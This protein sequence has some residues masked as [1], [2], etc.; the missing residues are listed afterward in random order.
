MWSMAT[1]ASVEYRY[2]PVKSVYYG[3]SANGM[4]MDNLSNSNTTTSMEKG[5][6]T[7]ITPIYSN[8][9]NTRETFEPAFEEDIYIGAG[10]NFSV[11]LTVAAYSDDDQ[12]PTG[13]QTY[14]TAE[15][16][17]ITTTTQEYNPTVVNATIDVGGLIKNAVV[18]A[19]QYVSGPNQYIRRYIWMFLGTMVELARVPKVSFVILCNQTKLPIS[20]TDGLIVGASVHCTSYLTLVRN[21]ISTVRFIPKTMRRKRGIL[22]KI[23]SSIFGIGLSKKV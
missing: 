5:S 12:W 1:S 15:A 11:P 9:T 8:N 17:V 22:N 14:V 21:P 18:V 7:D 23:K 4:H 10:T 13:N 2:D 19:S 3:I 6:W 20:P 16:T